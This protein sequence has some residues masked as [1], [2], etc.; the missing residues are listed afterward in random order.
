MTRDDATKKR[1][2]RLAW[3]LDSSIPI[4]WLNFR[5]GLESIL[6]LIPGVG[7]VIGALLSSYF[8]AAAYRLGVSKSTLIRMGGNVAVEAL[9]GAIPL[10]GDVFDF[11]WKA[12]QRN[13]RLL[14]AHVREPSRTDK[15][16]R[17]WVAIVGITIVVLI[18]A[19]VYLAM[20]FLRW[21]WVTLK[22]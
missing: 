8:L 19:S 22:T 3:L 11:A 1:L 14:Q 15:A 18:G 10:V 2:E 5:I 21:V 20:L 16:S 17:L 6:G 12:N 9:L 4:P 13:V 7:D